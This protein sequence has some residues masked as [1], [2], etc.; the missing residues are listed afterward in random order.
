M[1]A[2]I[3]VAP[4]QLDYLRDVVSD[5]YLLASCGEIIAGHGRLRSELLKWQALLEGGRYGEAQEYCSLWSQALT[6][7]ELRFAIRRF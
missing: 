6:K 3:P 5:A 4:F 1:V 7:Y 2:K